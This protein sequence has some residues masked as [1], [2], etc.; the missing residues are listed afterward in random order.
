MTGYRFVCSGWNDYC[1]RP[2]PAL[3]QRNLPESGDGMFGEK[4]RVSH[5]A[6]SGGLCL[7]P[8]DPSCNKHKF[9]HPPTD[10]DVRQA[11]KNLAD[12]GYGDALVRLARPNDPAPPSSLIY[13]VGV[14]DSCII[15]HSELIPVDGRGPIDEVTGKFPSGQCL[16]D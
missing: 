1:G 15:G 5:I 16:N 11:Q 8:T 9:R 2:V 7:T 4:A 10:E 3:G 13:A 14:G 12:A 6:T